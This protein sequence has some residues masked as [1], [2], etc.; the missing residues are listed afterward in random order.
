MSGPEGSSIKRF[1]PGVAGVA[2]QELAVVVSPGDFVSKS[3]ARHFYLPG[4][5]CALS[6]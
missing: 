4:Y 3:A 2:W 1:F 5:F 6:C